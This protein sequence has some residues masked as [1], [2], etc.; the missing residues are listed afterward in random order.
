MLVFFKILQELPF[1]KLSLLLFRS[2]NLR[3]LLPWHVGLTLED[4]AT[5][6][7]DYVAP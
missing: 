6:L 1:L 4:F 5:S 7:L 3:T 2:L